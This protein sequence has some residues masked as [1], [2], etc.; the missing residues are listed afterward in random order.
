MPAAHLWGFQHE[1][2]YTWKPKA[3]A[4]WR[5]YR[6]ISLVWCGNVHRGCHNFRFHLDRVALEFHRQEEICE[7]WSLTNDARVEGHD[8]QISFVGKL[9]GPGLKSSHRFGCFQR[10]HVRCQTRE[11]SHRGNSSAQ[12]M[13]VYVGQTHE[14]H[15]TTL[16]SR[17]Q[18]NGVLEFELA[19]SC[20]LWQINGMSIETIGTFYIDAV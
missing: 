11:T 15:R 5:T 13:S 8:G 4:S 17:R 2:S 12:Y 3:L 16:G 9:V 6:R 20:P 19:R 7:T 14:R 10:L 18:F 1:R